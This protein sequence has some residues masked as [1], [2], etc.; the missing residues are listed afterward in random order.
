MRFWIELCEAAGFGPRWQ[1]L[2]Q[3][4]LGVSIFIGLLVW[5]I[6]S[7]IGLSISLG[8]LS[9][10]A[11]LELLRMAGGQRQRNLDQSWPA[12][13]DL[14]RSG[15]QAGLSNEEQFRFMAQNGPQRLR[16]IFHQLSA[17]LENGNPLVESLARFQ[18]LSGSRNADFLALALAVSSELGGRGMSSI[19]EQSASEIRGEQNLLGEVLA[20]QSWVLASAK[21]ALL[22]PWLVAL[23]LL[24][25]TG[26]REAFAS[27][28]GTL[29]L[30]FGL[31]LS[32][33]A[34]FLTN[35]LGRLKLPGRIFHVA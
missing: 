18:Q 24:G 34:Y 33:A 20:R 3:V 17:D 16:P 6:T 8:L 35:L 31:M 23:L 30:L 12:V 13:F 29:V 25:P 26:N 15:A 1:Q 28:I 14:M 2:G 5:L 27:E 4:A 10:G 21:I 19:W 9:L 7:V 22:A 11:I 32:V